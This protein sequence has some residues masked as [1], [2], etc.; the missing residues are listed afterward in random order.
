MKLEKS[1]QLRTL[2]AQ[3]YFLMIFSFLSNIFIISYVDT[4]YE[5]LRT[6][7]AC[8]VSVQ[9]SIPVQTNYSEM[10]EYYIPVQMSSPEVVKVLIA[11][12]APQ[13]QAITNNFNI[14]TPC[15]YTR[16]Q[17]A[18]MLSYDSYQN[19]LPHLDTFILAEKTY[20]VNAFYLI[21]K[22]GLE[23]GWGEYTS[24]RNNIGGWQNDDGQYR[25]FANVD[26]C[27]LHIAKSLS[28]TYKESVGS[29]LKDVC[30]RYSTTKDY[31]YQLKRIMTQR[32]LKINEMTKGL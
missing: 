19:L 6:D 32:Q 13:P 29:K 12:P 17:L 16:E 2:T 23:S 5:K 18:Y 7:I 21:C 15:G 9:E 1:N 8:P 22:C 3:V 24:G 27:I 14:L 25:D 30:V 4:K 28:T 11:E 26:E 10:A 31:V 20:G